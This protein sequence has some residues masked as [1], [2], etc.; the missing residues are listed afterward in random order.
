[1]T[2]LD[3]LNSPK[4]D[5]TQNKSG[6]KIDKFQQSQALTSHFEN[7]WSIVKWMEEILRKLGL[8]PNVNTVKNLS[9][10]TKYSLCMSNQFTR[11]NLVIQ[12]TK[13]SCVVNAIET[14]LQ[15]LI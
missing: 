6:G 7:F 4:C 12:L 11:P 10:M 13:N 9:L 5:F 1:M 2:F 8:Q 15:N 3:C 14:V